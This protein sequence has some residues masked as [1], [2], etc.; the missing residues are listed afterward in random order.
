M[1][2]VADLILELSGSESEII[3]KPLPQDDP[4]RRCPDITRAREVLNWEPHTPARQGLEAT[5][6]WFAR[7][8]GKVV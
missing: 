5:I 2:E 4:K 3:N 1:K 8:M 7:K 6:A